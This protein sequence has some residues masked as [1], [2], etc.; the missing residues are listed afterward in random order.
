MPYIK[1]EKGKNQVVKDLAFYHLLEGKLPILDKRFDDLFD[2]FDNTIRL[3]A[4]ISRES[5]SNV[6]GDWYEWLL[7]LAAW[8]YFCNNPEANLCFLLPNISQF[9]VSQLYNDELNSLI[10][11]LRKKVR[12][13]SNVNL[14]TSN[15]DFAII[16]NK[17]ARQIL[18][19]TNPITDFTLDSLQFLATLYSNFIYQCDFFN[20]IGFCS[21]KTSLRPDRRLQMSHEGSLMKAIYTHLQTRNWV[22]SPPGLKYFGISRHVSPADRNAL[23]T[24]ATHSIT[25]VSSIPQAA[26]DEIYEI[27][28]LQE[29]ETVFQQILSPTK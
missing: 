28:S 15:P 10:K 14:I 25:I 19:D 13:S 20:L 17:L 16:E 23:K 18:S 8:N 27:N 5:L 4:T 9:D 29:A 12:D 21:V 6:H 11:D 1:I 22:L 2:E 3:R 26:V 24:V 7:A